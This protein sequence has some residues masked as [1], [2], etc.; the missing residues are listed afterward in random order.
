MID[1]VLCTFIPL[2]ITEIHPSL[3]PTALLHL[4]IQ[5]AEVNIY[6]LV[7]KYLPKKAEYTTYKG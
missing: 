3:I 2:F 5:F 1:A 7:S 6:P 4:L